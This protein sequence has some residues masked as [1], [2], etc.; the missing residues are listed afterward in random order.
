VTEAMTRTMRM[1]M[2]PNIAG[3]RWIYYGVGLIVG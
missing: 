2:C 3:H 1:R